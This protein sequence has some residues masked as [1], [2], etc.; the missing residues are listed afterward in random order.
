M[1]QARRA[2][3]S[4]EILPIR[5]YG[6]DVEMII[7]G[8]TPMSDAGIMEYGTL[9]SPGNFK[10]D[11]SVHE[12]APSKDNFHDTDKPDEEDDEDDDE[13]EEEEDD[14]DEEEDE[15]EDDDGKFDCSR[16]TL[17]GTGRG[18]PPSWRVQP[19]GAVVSKR[20]SRTP[21]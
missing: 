9:E 3:Q 16:R 20:Y 15:E 7:E 14:H 17:I 10:G 2:E 13:G 12:F 11:S 8:L 5:V 1:S 4:A 21:G 6:S 18:Q 19:A